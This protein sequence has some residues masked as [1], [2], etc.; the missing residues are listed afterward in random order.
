MQVKFLLVSRIDEDVCLF[1]LQLQDVAWA[2]TN[3]VSFASSEVVQLPFFC[4]TECL[5][6]FLVL[7]PEPSESLLVLMQ[8]LGVLNNGGSPRMP[9]EADA[10]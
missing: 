10:K 4:T 5:F 8:L 1:S 2:C 3:R 7:L 9:D 6:R